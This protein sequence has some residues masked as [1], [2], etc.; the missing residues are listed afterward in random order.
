M[1]QT[2]RTIDMVYGINFVALKTNMDC[3]LSSLLLTETEGKLWHC[4][5]KFCIVPDGLTYKLK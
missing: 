1:S 2:V 5:G 3:F 4:V